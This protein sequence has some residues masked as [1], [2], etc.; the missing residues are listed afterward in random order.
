MTSSGRRLILWGAIGVLMAAGLF[1]A[2]REQPIPVDLV[3][4]D[5]GPVTVT[6]D[7]EGR[8]RV[9]DIYT[10]SAPIAGSL[11]RIEA[12]AGDAVIAEVSVLAAIR[13]TEPTLLDAREEARVR[14]EIEAARANLALA[15]A[16]VDRATADLSFAETELIRARTLVERAAA[17][18][19]SLDL[20][21]TERD[22][23]RAA[24]RTSEAQVLARAAELDKALAELMQATDAA[25]LGQEGCCIHVIAPI[26]GHVLRVIH[27]NEGVVAAGEA[28][29]EL[30]AL[31]DMEVLVEALST[32][33]VAVRKG[34]PVAIERWGGGR[35]LTGTVRRVEPY[36]FTKISAL[37]IEEQRVNVLIDFDDPAEAATLLGH[38]YRVETRVR[39]DA[40]PDA[41]RAPLAALFR[42]GG[43]WAVF[44]VA[45]GR[46]DKRTVTVGLM[47]DRVVE[48]T[49]GLEPGDTLILR[50]DSRI[51]PDV[52]VAEREG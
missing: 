24:L 40:E 51:E 11:Q 27:E 47:N 21:R 20:A 18:E 31:D 28:L 46:A 17:S 9:R 3:A 41:V 34:A 36:G 4:V 29:I 22:R 6:L 50:P 37:G 15:R 13:P 43:D 35:T 14:A 44:A 33:A 2:F 49:E 5:R 48:I 7:E 10:L 1:L 16:E 30:G 12:N 25:D 8:T 19:R 42:D 32:E 39:I 23:A 45:D 26:S 52:L 38:G